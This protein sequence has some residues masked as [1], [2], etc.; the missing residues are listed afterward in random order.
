MK[1]KIAADH[2]PT[3]QRQEHVAD[4]ADG[5]VGQ[6]PLDVALRPAR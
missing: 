4:L 3:P 6:H 2:A 1:W 5:G